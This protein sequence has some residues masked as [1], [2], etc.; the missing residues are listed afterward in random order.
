MKKCFEFEGKWLKVVDKEQ[1]IFKTSDGHFI[2]INGDPAPAVEEQSEE[3]VHTSDSVWDSYWIE[4]EGIEE[5]LVAESTTEIEWTLDDDGFGNFGF[6][7]KAGEFVIEPQYACAKEFTCGLAAVNLN[8]TWFRSPDG[9]R[10]YENHYGFINERGET[11]IPF[12]YADAWSF[13]KY[14]VAVVWPIAG[15]RMLID[16]KGDIVPGTEEFDFSYYYEYEDRFLQF[17]YKGEDYDEGAPIGVY[18]TKE[19][20]V[21]FEPS[22]DDIIEFD[23]EHI[24]VYERKGEYGPSDTRQYYINSKGEPLY[25]WLVGKDFAIAEKPNEAKLAVVAISEYTELNG[26]VKS[27]Y[28]PHNGK[29]YDRRYIY[30]VYSAEGKFEIPLEYDIIKEISENIFACKKGDTVT[31]YQYQE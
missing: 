17:T 21:L 16:L 13:N 12:A 7:N 26:N 8:R 3:T 14:G 19:R 1:L 15:A 18:D 29:K 27:A 11:V 10:Y 4:Y 23:E 25:P 30:G 22:L 24:L 5:K 2:D 20:K 28:V 6:K 9:K 31:V